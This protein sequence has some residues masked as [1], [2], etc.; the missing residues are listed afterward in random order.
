MIPSLRAHTCPRRLRGRGHLASFALLLLI[1]GI[2]G[3][4]T[5]PAEPDAGVDVDAFLPDG[6]GADA[7]PPCESDEDC[8]DGVACTRD[9]CDTNATCR[10][11]PDP[12][13]CDDEI[14]CNGVEQCDVDRGCVPGTRQTCNDD[15]VCTIDRCNEETKECDHFA[16]DLDEDGDADFFCEGGGD[17]DDRDPLRSSAVAEICDD[18]IDND[19]DDLVDEATC[20]R[21]RYDVCDDPLDVSAGGVFVVDTSGATPDYMLGCGGTRPDLVLTFTLTEPRQVRIEAEG[22]FFTTSL[23]LRTTCT[24]R[25]T[26]TECVSGFPGEI[27]LRSLDAGTYFVL[28]TGS[29]TGEIAIDVEFTEPTP[30]PTN[31]TCATPIDVSAGGTFTGTMLDADDDLTTSCGFGGAPDLVYVLTTTTERDVRITATA[32]T[33]E[34]LSWEL[35]PTCDATAGSIRCAYGGPA[36]GRIHQLPAGTYYIVLEGPTFTEIDFSLVVELLD[37]TPPL[38]G[39]LCSNAIPLTL[40]TPTPGTLTD[41]EDDLDVSCGFHYRDVVYS[42]SLPARRDV[43]VEIAGG[44]TF[45]NAS[46]RPDCA[47]GGT[48]IRCSSGAPLRMRMRDLAADTYYVVAEASRAASFTITVT[49]TAPTVPTP[50]T[51]NDT[52]AS[53]H[54]VP[55]TGGLFTGTT[56]GLADDVRTAACGGM[57]QS[58]DAVFRL[59]LT[60]RQRVVASTDG[61]SYDTVLHMHNTMCRTGAESA[62][63]DDG[64]EGA[65]SLLDRTL[66]AGTY[67]FV[68]DGWGMVSSGSYVFEVLV[69]DP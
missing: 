42:F 27:R 65:T 40:G 25:T 29:S 2:G 63:D 67:F 8:D 54:V 18:A 52:C 62:C 23:A 17:C 16:R 49:D 55:A 56:V 4:E 22:D 41:R 13:S 37:P 57:A 21:P 47:D 45:L 66:D 28:L 20:G 50:V 39:D 35:R 48:Q 14:F 60:T 26:E 68:V 11:A 69:S 3:C 44:T 59:D 1:A 64:G 46:V 7:G 38:A 51:G 5:P 19:C 61:S 32:I 58:P 43:T 9:V 12:A 31:E 15:Q 30:P 36:T 10:N 34:S 33:G 24:D 6:G 53:A